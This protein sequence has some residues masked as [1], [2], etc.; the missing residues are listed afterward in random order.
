MRRVW[1]SKMRGR[2]Y[3]GRFWKRALEEDAAKLAG[4]IA[5]EGEKEDT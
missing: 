2:G 3:M 1:L 4:E 5:E